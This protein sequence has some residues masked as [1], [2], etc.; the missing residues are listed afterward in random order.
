MPRTI[1]EP[2]RIKVVEPLQ[3]TTRGERE[4]LLS[5]AGFN[6]FELP[7][8]AVL[9]DLLTDSGTGAMSAAQWGAMMI[10][11]ESYAGARSFHRF[12]DAV[13][14]ITGYPEVIPT[15]QGRAA[16]HLL[17]ELIVGEGQRVVSNTLFDTTRANTEMAGGEGVD[18]PCR[19]ADDLESD[20]PFKGDID[21][22][23]LAHHLAEPERIA[24]VILTITNNSVAGQP[25]SLDNARA[26]SDLCKK[27]GVLFFIDAARFAENA[28]LSRERDP[29]LAD[30]PL[31]RIARAY[32]DL[33]DGCTMSAKKDGMANIGGFLALRD[34]KLARKARQA[35]VV[36]EG[37]PTYGGLAG[38]DL[39]AI[40]VGLREALAESYQAYRHASIKYMTDRLAA[41]GI[42][43]V[44]PAGGHAVYLDAARFFDHIPA[45]QFPGQALAVALYLHG[46]VRACEIGSV[47]FGDIDDDGKLVTPSARE[48]V[49]LAF[50]RRVYTQSH[51]DYLC[52]VIEELYEAR[53]E[54]PGI[55]VVEAPPVLR[56]FS[57]RFAQ[58]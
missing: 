16:E 19:A 15:H 31:P 36:T 28:Y 56:H 34:T 21:L 47:M 53:H 12:R 45:D 42:P 17:F 43:H 9:I 44:R 30:W 22:D 8:E 49:R 2:F 23:A 5:K 37:F 11:D 24:A 51:V 54:Q 10:G 3:H 35:L 39:D 6:L 33:A 14:D 38:R 52:E 13:T 50:P 7:A 40:A 20:A 29:A 55:R 57:A 4:Q 1:I 58:L 25:V 27:A 41:R 48:L 18:I 26:A 32:F 46:G